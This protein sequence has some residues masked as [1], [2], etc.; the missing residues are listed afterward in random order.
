MGLAEPLPGVGLLLRIKFLNQDCNG[1]FPDDFS[2]CMTMQD[3][4][5][6]FLHIVIQM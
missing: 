3:A 5:I 4:D 1:E 6:D 2:G